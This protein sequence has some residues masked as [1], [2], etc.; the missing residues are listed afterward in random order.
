VIEHDDMVRFDKGY[1]V[2]DGAP[3]IC[4]GE[5][6]FRVWRNGVRYVRCEGEIELVTEGA[7]PEGK[8]E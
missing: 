8:R 7:R 3:L 6:F 5:K 4:G 2:V 1:G